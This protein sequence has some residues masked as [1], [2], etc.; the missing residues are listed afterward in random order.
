M[1][2][3]SAP[4]HPNHPGIP[5]PKGFNENPPA[6]DDADPGI[7]RVHPKELTR[8]VCSWAA[9]LEKSLG[10][11]WHSWQTWEIWG[12]AKFPILEPFFPTVSCSNSR[13]LQPGIGS[14]IPNPGQ[15]CF[16]HRKRDFLTFL[17]PSSWFGMVSSSPWN[18]QPQIPPEMAQIFQEKWDKNLPKAGIGMSLRRQKQEGESLPIPST[19]PVK[20]IGWSSPRILKLL[21]KL[22]KKRIQFPLEQHN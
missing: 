2:V 3:G 9:W 17:P 22:G 21:G 10:D 18:S 1:I 7:P 13:S 20:L 6:V 14:R 16:Q 4:S 19:I 5:F 12:R 15:K 11:C 8:S